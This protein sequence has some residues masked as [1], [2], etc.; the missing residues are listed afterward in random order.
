ME[1]GLMNPPPTERHEIRLKWVGRRRGRGR[2]G[3]FVSAVTSGAGWLRLIGGLW[4]NGRSYRTMEAG[5]MNLPPT[6]QH[7]AG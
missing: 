6:E 4:G 7:E 2:D 5:R 1:A 3:N